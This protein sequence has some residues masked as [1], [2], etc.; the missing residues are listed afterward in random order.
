MV[1]VTTFEG[2][3]QEFHH[4]WCPLMYKHQECEFH[5]TGKFVYPKD[6]TNLKVNQT[7]H[8]AGPVLRLPI[9]MLPTYRAM[10]ELQKKPKDWVG[11]VDDIG[12]DWFYVL[13]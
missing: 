7:T 10:I 3:Q 13:G 11:N 6:L 2:N 12:K 1:I 5:V 4:Y 9:N 8:K